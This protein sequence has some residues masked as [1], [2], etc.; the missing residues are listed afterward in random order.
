MK[1]N[2]PWS[3]KGIERDVRETAK[4]AARREGMTVGEWLSQVIYAAS[5]PESSN[6]EIEGLKISDLVT[7]IEHLNKR[8]INAE[9]KSVA[10]VD[11]LSRN[12][13]GVVERMQ[14]LERSKTGEA[15]PEIEQRLQQLEA[16]TNDR[17]R[18][19]TL[20]ALEKAVAQVALQYD[21]AH[22]QTLTRMDA[23]ERQLQEL[24]S[25]LDLVGTGGDGEEGSLAAV[26][27]LKRAVDAMSERVARAETIAAEASRLNAEATGS[28]DA[29]FVERTGARLRILGDE[30]KRSNDQIRTLESTIKKLSDQID[31][32]EKRSSE[33]VEKVADTITQLK[34]QILEAEDAKIDPR[35]EIETAITAATQRT[36]ERL[37]ELQRALETAVAKIETQQAAAPAPTAVAAPAPVKAEPAAPQNL[38]VEEAQEAEEEEPGDIDTSFEAF[39][40]DDEDKLVEVADDEEEDEDDAFAFDLDKEAEAKRTREAALKSG[41]NFA[42]VSQEEAPSDAPQ[43]GLDAI[44]AEFDEL[45]TQEEGAKAESEDA[46]ESL[47]EVAEPDEEEEASEAATD[48]L[49]RARRAA[50]EFGEA[51]Q[52]EEIGNRR[53]LS[54]KQ[55]ALLAAKIRRKR[56]AEET[57]RTEQEAAPEAFPVRQQEAQAGMADEGAS[58]ASLFSRAKGAMRSRMP[59]GQAKE[60]G[61]S[62]ALSRIKTKPVTI[63]L[64]VAIILAATALFFLVK[65]LMFAGSEL[66]QE[67]VA[68]S[69]A[70]NQAP[71]LQGPQTPT[72]KPAVD[73]RALY[74]ASVDKLRTAQNDAEMKE[75]IDGIEQA[76]ALGHPPAQLQLG[77]LYKLGQ[78]VEQDLAQ[79]RLWYERAANGGNVLAMHRIGVME[80]RG[81]GG[82]R[83]EAGAIKWFE[84]ASKLGLVDSQYNLGA[85]YHP[86]GGET[87]DVPRDAAKAYYWYSLAARNGDDQA[88]ALAAALGSTLPADR[89]KEIDAAVASWK[90]EKP[91]VEANEVASAS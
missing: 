30:I 27:D 4:E 65:D 80:A 73:P 15:G 26:A 76:A 33:G 23:T 70:D 77:E 89:R 5:D 54:A 16:K 86:G 72:A 25:R 45:Q 41:G 34:T 12:F 2:A 61:E 51:A 84:K 1:S 35:Q 24:A 56:L 88:S 20:R 81:Q 68:A 21:S 13:G 42:S 28:A 3:V 44:L 66:K 83:D 91:D 82:P 14:R 67:R 90:A 57:S 71:K 49:A 58:S 48:L 38:A 18:I 32:A 50:K 59:G 6:G 36:D 9:S 53:R 47:F 74:F 39:D 62:D 29:E 75:A 40:L 43:N 8:V 19:E 7:A 37:A 52:P 55:R 69:P 60:A 10:A 46:D 79:A 87:G 11:E 63:A 85:L 17:Q 64:G 31:A 22:K 78:G